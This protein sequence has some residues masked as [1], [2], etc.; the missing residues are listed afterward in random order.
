[1]KS[2]TSTVGTFGPFS[3]IVVETDYYDCDGQHYPFSVVGND[4]TT[5]DYVPPPITPEVPE[6]V[7]PLQLDEALIDFEL[8]E[9]I[10][11]Y[12]ET[13]TNIEKAKFHRAKRMYRN[14]LF[15]VTGAKALGMTD[16]QIDAV[17]IRAA[18]K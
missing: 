2:L 18:T 5:P 1:M 16:A 9:P 11:T 3:S 8:Y 15:L 14:D 4:C 17:F 6:W 10:Y 12:V 7:E 13:A